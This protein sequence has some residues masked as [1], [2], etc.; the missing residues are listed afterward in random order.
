[1]SDLYVFLQKMVDEKVIC[2]ASKSIQ[3]PFVN[4]FFFFFFVTEK[5]KVLGE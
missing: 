4:G 1:M 2:H 3:Q 5:D